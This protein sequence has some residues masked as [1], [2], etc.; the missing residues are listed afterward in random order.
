[1]NQVVGANISVSANSSMSMM[2]ST[3]GVEYIL[4]STQ[5]DELKAASD[6]IANE[7]LDRPEVTKVHTTLENAAPV[8]KLDIDALKANA[9]NITPMQIAA[10]VN[11]MLSGKEATT[12]DVDGD[13]ISVMV[14]YP[15]DEYNTIDKLQGIVLT[16][17]TGSSVALTDVAEIGFKDSPTSITR[18]DK[19][20]QVTITGDVLTDDPREQ[21]AIEKTLYD[22]VVTNT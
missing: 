19:Q 5:Y 12:L 22:E 3:G 2:S 20:Y 4:Q 1:M 11:M 15:K 8:V 17:N 7:L 10:T 16:T 14:E 18:K 13:E 21:D 6:S 9:E